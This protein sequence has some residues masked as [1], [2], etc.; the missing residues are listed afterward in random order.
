MRQIKDWKTIV[1]E[2][3][4]IL[5]ILVILYTS[6]VKKLH[7]N[8]RGTSILAKNILKNLRDSYWNNDILNC[9]K[10]H[11]EC[12]PKLLSKSINSIS[13]GSIRDA[14]KRNWKGIIL[15]HLNINSTRNKFDL[16]V[17]QIKGNVDI[18]VISETIRLVFP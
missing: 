7:L 6:G 8:K 1:N 10:K 15:G 2:K 17:D 16:L 14:C 4:L 3:I 13:F 5:L 18:M 9:G 12:K 11:D